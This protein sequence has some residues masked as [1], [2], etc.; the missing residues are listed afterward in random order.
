MAQEDQRWHHSSWHH[1][2]TIQIRCSRR[3]SQRIPHCQY[4][5]IHNPH[6]GLWAWDDRSGMAQEEKEPREC[7][8]IV[9]RRESSNE[10]RNDSID[11]TYAG[12]RTEAAIVIRHAHAAIKTV[13]PGGA[14]R[15]VEGLVP[16]TS[17]AKNINPPN[18]VAR[19]HRGRR[20]H[21]WDLTDRGTSCRQW[22]RGMLRRVLHR[23]RRSLEN[24]ELS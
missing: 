10:L 21:C 16:I 6:R 14:A 7:R 24:A 19:A 23:R 5:H 20:P 13:T 2:H 1:S 11:T 9:S 3:L 8:V 22:R 4:A 17:I 15:H 12:A 18:G